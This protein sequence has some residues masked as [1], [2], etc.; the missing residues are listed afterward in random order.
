VSKQGQ[1]GLQGHVHCS[2]RASHVE[3]CGTIP[4]LELHCSACVETVSALG[5]AANTAMSQ[6][7]QGW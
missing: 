1:L 3:T 4:A 2:R 7:G 6:A 5:C